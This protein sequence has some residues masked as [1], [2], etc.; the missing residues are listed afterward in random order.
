MSKIFKRNFALNM[1]H[2][3]KL[4]CSRIINLLLIDECLLNQ[5]IYIKTKTYIN[6]RTSKRGRNKRIKNAKPLCKTYIGT[7]CIIKKALLKSMKIQMMM[8]N[9][10]NSVTQREKSLRKSPLPRK[11]RNPRSLKIVNC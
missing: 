5:Y 4:F 1:G 3:F 11:N 6:Y 10:C 7:K 8:Q 2:L 9:L